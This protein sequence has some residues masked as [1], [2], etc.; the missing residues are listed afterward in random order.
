MNSKMDP[1]G[2]AILDYVKRQGRVA[3]YWKTK[4]ADRLHK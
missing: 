3:D 1:M 2:R 4:K